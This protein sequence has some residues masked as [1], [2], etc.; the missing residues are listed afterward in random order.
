[1]YRRYLMPFSMRAD[2]S[3]R[4]LPYIKPCTSAP[5]KNR[6]KHGERPEMNGDP[7]LQA[8]LDLELVSERHKY[9]NDAVRMILERRP[10]AA[11]ALYQF[12]AFGGRHVY[13]LL[14][15][16]ALGASA[17]V[18]ELLWDAYPPADDPGE[19]HPLGGWTPLIIALH[20]D[21]SID[22]VQLLL[23]RF[24]VALQRRDALGGLPLHYACSRATTE[25]VRLLAESCPEAMR[26]K[27]FRGMT[28]LHHACT[29]RAS[30][31][32]V[33][34]LVNK[35]PEALQDG[36]ERGR[37]PLHH[38]C[39]HG[40]PLLVVRFLL[41]S[42]VRTVE[43]KD[44]NGLTPLVLLEQRVGGV[45][46]NTLV[47]IRIAL[48][49]VHLNPN[50]NGCEANALKVLEEFTKLRWWRGSTLLLDECPSI[51]HSLCLKD[52]ALPYLL[53]KLSREC[54]LETM[55]R[56]LRGLAG[57]F[58]HQDPTSS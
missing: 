8:L 10:R 19:G 51:M 6:E 56:T 12:R 17:D 39:H 40:A 27:D 29:S 9:D 57:V 22:V 21:A 2:F 11:S 41:E 5:T 47:S 24:P 50:R 52:E 13:P 20:Y 55:F 37:I 58:L 43:E 3:I 45:C 16:I 31:D 25:V 14:V 15:A 7:A 32:V 44:W 53:S 49:L 18:V 1:M 34:L 48:A 54:K 23:R 28:P 46:S 35:C 30:L 38:A 26:K 36:D 33:R 42:R 4:I